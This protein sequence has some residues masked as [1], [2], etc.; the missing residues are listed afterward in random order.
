[1]GPANETFVKIEGESYLALIYSG[2][3]LLAI[4]ESLVTKLYLKIHKLDTLIGAEA[5]GEV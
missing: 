3:Q 5:T 4:P 2:A 1:M